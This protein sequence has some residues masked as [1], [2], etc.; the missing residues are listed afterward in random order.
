MQGCEDHRK[1]KVCVPVSAEKLGPD[2][3]INWRG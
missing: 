3:Q 2:H 1:I